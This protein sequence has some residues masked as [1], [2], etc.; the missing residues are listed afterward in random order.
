M[1]DN[2]HFFE[3]EV[4]RPIFPIESYE[5]IPLRGP[6]LQAVQETSLVQPP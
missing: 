4:N 5:E 6:L 2:D 3:F 1:V